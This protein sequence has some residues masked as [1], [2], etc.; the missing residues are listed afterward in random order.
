MVTLN[1]RTTTDMSQRYT[2]IND[3]NFEVILSDDTFGPH[4]RVWFQRNGEW[5]DMRIAFS[6]ANIR[7]VDDLV[8]HVYSRGK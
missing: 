8:Q 6:L 7:H 4:L 2:E 5:L 1:I 3:P